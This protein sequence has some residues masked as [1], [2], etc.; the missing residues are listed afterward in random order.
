VDGYPRALACTWHGKEKGVP[1]GTPFLPSEA[2]HSIRGLIV[3]AG[4]TGSGKTTTQA[5]MVHHLNATRTRHIVTIE[6]PIEYSHTNIKSK[7]V[8]RQLGGDTYSFAQAL[9]N[10]L[11][12]DPDVILVG[13]MRDTETAAAIIQRL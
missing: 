7:I 5:A 11:R 10:I 2:G 13:E 6:D 9:K 1:S 8:Q 3:I 4:P 12:H